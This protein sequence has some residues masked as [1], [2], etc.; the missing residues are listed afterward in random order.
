MNISWVLITCGY[1]VTG[2]DSSVHDL[3]RAHDRRN[4][5]LRIYAVYICIMQQS[6][7]LKHLYIRNSR[8]VRILLHTL[9]DRACL[10]YLCLIRSKL[11]CQF[12][13]IYS[14]SEA[15]K[16]YSLLIIM[17]LNAIYRLTYH[18][19]VQCLGKW[20]VICSRTSH[21]DD[22]FLETYD[23]TCR[24]NSHSFQRICLTFAYSINLSD[25]AR[26]DSSSSFYLNSWLDDVLNR[27]DSYR[28]TWLCNIKRYALNLL[29]LESNRFYGLF[30]YIK[31][32]VFNLRLSR[33]LNILNVNVSH[34]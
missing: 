15:C 5:L 21:I 28:F 10:I 16:T 33:K 8:K 3:C 12:P 7:T 31:D 20:C 1:T 14:N 13:K 30:G 4:D 6:L 29:V 32:T 11:A 23:L 2:H 26:E 24:N 22:T 34:F 25:H 27:C 18:N 19:Q 9:F 17:L